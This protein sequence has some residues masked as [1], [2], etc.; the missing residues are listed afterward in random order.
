MALWKVLEAGA[1]LLLAGALVSLANA[2]DLHHSCSDSA[3]PFDLVSNFEIVVQGQLGELSGLRFILDTGSS[4][5]TLD[6]RVA[7]RMGLRRRPGTVFSFDRSLAVEWVEVPEVRI[8]ALRVAR[9][10]MMVARLGDLSEFAKD[11]DGIIGIDVLSRARTICIDYERRSVYIKL[12]KERSKDAPPGQAFVIPAT[13]QGI[14]MHLLVDTGLA[15][16]LLYKDRLRGAIPDMDTRG[17]A[18]NALLG[19]LRAE[20]V[21]LPQLQIGGFHRRTGVLLIER[22]ARADLDGV[23]G[24]LGPAAVHARRL[25]FDFAERVLRWEL[26]Q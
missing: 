16:V 4:Y 9:I 25:E 24:Y 1:R 19:R 3:M 17:E 18:R 11:A 2:Q 20:Q 21:D 8:G 10:S 13:I 23:D 14:P 12:D 5:S 6:R 22:P 7:D 15:Y 26:V